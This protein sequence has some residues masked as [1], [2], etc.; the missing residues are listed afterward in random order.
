MT[1]Y[2]IWPATSGPGS[3]SADSPVNLATEFS[4]S[5]T[6]WLKAIR[7]WRA[8]LGITGS[9]QGRVWLATSPSAGTAVAGT[10]VTFVLSG[11]G[12][13]VANL[14]TPVQ[15]TAGVRYKAA[16]LFP[17]GYS[18]TANYWSSGGGAGG[19]TNGILTAPNYSGSAGGD[20]QGCYAYASSLTYPANGSPN[21]G[22]YWVDVIVTDTDPGGG[23]IR[24]VLDLA[25]ETDTAHVL[26]VSRRVPLTL[27]SELDTAQQLT[28]AHTVPLGLAV[29][30]DTASVLTVAKA[31][32]LDQAVELDTAS[33]ITTA[34]AVPLGLAVEQDTALPITVGGSLIVPGTH[35][36]TA[37]VAQLTAGSSV[38]RLEAW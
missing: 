10:D 31:V 16:C 38:A 26:T 23:E 11:T 36:A 20:T 28:I 29:E 1:D 8:D 24:V 7:F 3:S 27:A 21:A 9:V 6:G 30:T 2:S 18:A 22:G 17:S 33:P 37:A 12:W 32:L 13:Q 15:L 35:T 34:K 25:T 19:I 14:V 5:A 4:L